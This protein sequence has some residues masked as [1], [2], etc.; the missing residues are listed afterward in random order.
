MKK[1]LSEAIGTFALVFV[2]TGAIIVND[3][4][5]GAIS[6]VGV[7]LA[8]GL[9]VMIMICSVGDVSGAH[10][11]PAVTIGF[12]AARRLPGQELFPYIAAQCAGAL[13]ASVLL[14]F[15]FLSHAGLGVTVPAGALSHRNEIAG[16]SA[17]LADRQLAYLHAGLRLGAEHNELPADPLQHLSIVFHHPVAALD[18]PGSAVRAVN[19]NL[20]ADR[21]VLD[22]RD[23][24]ILAGRE[25]PLPLEADI[26]K[27]FLRPGA[28]Q[29][30]R[31][32][33]E[34]SH[35][36][37]GQRSAGGIPGGPD[38]DRDERHEELFRYSHG[39]AP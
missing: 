24:N 33:P 5:G 2:G 3:L 27:P 7:A 31:D 20:R 29:Q 34:Q 38:R 6:H 25:H 30:H 32:A 36:L 14:R 37:A 22:A 4:T 12:W 1:P 19:V 10:L 23:R 35:Q 21:V 16:R 17:P 15:L 8:F 13:V 18:I 26:L 11:N 9:I 39:F 28:H